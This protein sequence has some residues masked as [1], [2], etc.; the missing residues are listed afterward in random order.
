M[1]TEA[2]PAAATGPT[3]P[4]PLAR[5]LLVEHVSGQWSMAAFAAAMVIATIMCVALPGLRNTR[6]ATA[7]SEPS[8]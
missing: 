2:E 8:S 1:S 3:P 5:S 4:V 6:N 7:T